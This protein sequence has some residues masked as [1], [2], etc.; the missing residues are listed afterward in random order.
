MS[1]PRGQW[2]VKARRSKE[3]GDTPHSQHSSTHALVVS[4]SVDMGVC[5]RRDID[6]GPHC[7]GPGWTNRVDSVVFVTLFLLF[8]VVPSPSLAQ[9]TETDRKEGER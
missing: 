7:V 9:S 4:S 1:L 8:F 2:S 6:D 3:N 5:A